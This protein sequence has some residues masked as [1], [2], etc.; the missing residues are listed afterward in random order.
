MEISM[1]TIGGE[2]GR[3]TSWE[4]AD[5]AELFTV[6]PTEKKEANPKLYIVKHL[7]ME[8]Q[9]CDGIVLWLDCD[10]EGENICF[11]V[12]DAVNGYL[13]S[14]TNVW[15]ARFSAITQVEITTALANLIKPDKEAAQAVDARQELDLRVGC[16]FTRFQTKYFQGRYGDLDSSLVSFGPCQTPTLALCVSRH[17]EIQAFRPENYWLLQPM[18]V[19]PGGVTLSLDWDRGRVFD[20]EVVLALLA[21]ARSATNAQVMS[22]TSK[23]RT[24]AR[25]LPLNTVELLRVGSSALGMS[26]QHTMQVAEK[27]YTQG[28][29]SY[30][31][32]ET[33]SYPS[34]FDLP[35]SLRLLTSS[36]EWGD[37][38]R[39]LLEE[40]LNKPRKG[41]DAGDHPPITPCLLAT[42]SQLGSEAWR[43]YDYICRH[44]IATVS[45]DLHYL[46]K[47]LSFWLGSHAEHSAMGSE[48]IGGEFF[49]ATGHY[50]VSPGFT[51]AMPWLGLGP[52]SALPDLVV[53]SQVPVEEVH[54]LERQTSPP[55]YLTEAE[56]I[57]LMEKHGIGTDASIPVHINNICQRNY[58]TVE[59]GRR[60][61]P[62]SLGVVLIH[63]Y[64]QIDPELSLPG[65]RAE[66]ERQLGL[67]ALGQADFRSVLDHAL[68]IFKRKFHYFVEN[69]AGMDELMEVSFSPLA[70]SGKPH[71]RCG[72]C[73]RY[74]KY[75]QARPSR[76]HCPQCGD[77][78]SLPPGGSLRT[79]RDLS[80]PL[81]HFE[82]V[83]WVG[84]PGGGGGASRGEA[85]GASTGRSFPLCPYC[86]NNP[87]FEGMRKGQGCPSCLHPSCPHGERAL[88]VSRCGSCQTGLVLLDPV[89][90]P[91][92]IFCCNRC[93]LS[94]R[95]FR[96]ASR[97]T[98]LPAQAAAS[99]ME[100]GTF[101]CARSSLS[102]CPTCE[103]SLV[104]VE[105]PNSAPSPLLNSAPLHIGCM[106]CDSAL[107]P[108]VDSPTV[109]V[110]SEGSTGRGSRRGGRRGRGSGR[111]GWGSGGQGEAGRG[112]RPRDKM[113]ALA[114]YFV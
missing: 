53:G 81:D 36:S 86:F 87:P 98:V 71:S 1:E 90:G 27:L 84:G 8:A 31:R 11:E 104:R 10:K 114:A 7:Q 62:T 13:A 23:E 70:A 6:A 89:S 34:S 95:A 42:E 94:I 24:K 45:P 76:L 28:Y 58:V 49:T 111:S 4:L 43:L 59:S 100:D 25:P 33:S 22:V 99:D 106:F 85:G 16:A 12:L 9:G 39:G 50:L 54:M 44:F 101:G 61:K 47:E 3:Y 77:S 67:I 55:N 20:R 60:L 26:P 69:I 57:G 110:G 40:G 15:R 107:S 66:V 56:L 113:A 52:D 21:I 18:V 93:P 75:I 108:L 32:T 88:A 73:R 103:A 105:Y 80:C 74:M 46:H 102:V 48:E 92:W 51:Q 29:I 79:Y 38:A 109:R 5:P 41:N 82:L 19:L 37:L 78:Y 63:G 91:R 112:H 65:M 97:V 68:D 96:N 14:Q 64:Q 72:K 17:D 35:A 2:F 83:L 30:P